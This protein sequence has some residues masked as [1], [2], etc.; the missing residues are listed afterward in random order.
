M[1]WLLMLTG[2]TYI[3]NLMFESLMNRIYFEC[4]TYR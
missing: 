4:C 2:I 1:G 3:Y